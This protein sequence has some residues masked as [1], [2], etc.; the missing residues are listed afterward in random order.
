M[1]SLHDRREFLGQLA[2][3]PVLAAGSQAL[4]QSPVLKPTPDPYADAV[5]VNG[6]PPLPAPGSF[7]VAVLPDTQFY[8]ETYPESYLM[9]TR[10][11]VENQAKRNIA[12][13]LH[14]GDIT[15]RNTPR[16]WQ[17]AAKAMK[18]LDGHLPYFF[19]TGNHD[20]GAGGG[21]K[22]R[23]THLDTYFP[24]AQFKNR[25]TFGGTYDREP[26]RMENSY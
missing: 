15:N 18:Q 8:S 2:A 9:Q 26:D 22:D 19:C 20:Y 25:P 10:W 16:E 24:V 6:E 1:M 21:C 3:L 23:S 4:A 5:L 13:V 7:T 11:L 14:L 12:C 17:N